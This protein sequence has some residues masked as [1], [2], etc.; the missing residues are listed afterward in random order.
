MEEATTEV[1]AAMRNDPKP[2]ESKLMLP[3]L[4]KTLDADL[5]KKYV[6]LVDEV[7]RRRTQP[8]KR[9]LKVGDQKLVI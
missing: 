6:A 9:L 8:N 7:K 4:M 1:L 3:Q 5:E 2:E